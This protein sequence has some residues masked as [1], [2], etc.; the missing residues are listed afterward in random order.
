MHIISNLIWMLFGGLWLALLWGLVGIILCITVIGIPFGIQCF[1]MAK[2]SF[3]PY[4]KRVNSNFLKHPVAN[5]VWTVFVGW[6]MAL[7]YF[8]FG[9]LNCI[10]VIGIP[11]GFQ[12][13]KMM[14]LAFFPFGAKVK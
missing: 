2:L 8:I 12:C 3:M 4:G 6:E 10:T 9:A 14:K 11:R 5:T 7:V 1:K 13:F